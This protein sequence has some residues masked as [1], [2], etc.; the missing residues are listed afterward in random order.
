MPLTK[1]QKAAA[2]ARGV[3]N[4]SNT[5]ARIENSTGPK[6]STPGV[7]KAITKFRA[8]AMNQQLQASKA[9]DSALKKTKKKGVLKKTK[10]RPGTG[11]HPT[12][13]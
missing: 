6:G 10:K 4:A 1:E 3:L 12:N 7:R 2:R 11:I 9:Y 13:R 5:I 8:D